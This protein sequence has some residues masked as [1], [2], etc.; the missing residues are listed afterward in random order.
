MI[1]PRFALPVLPPTVA[2]LLSGRR[3]TTHMKHAPVQAVVSAHVFSYVKALHRFWCRSALMGVNLGTIATGDATIAD[4]SWDLFRL[5]LDVA[6]G[7]KHACAKN[8][9]PH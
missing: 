9:K 4:V 7:R 5:M 2:F 6:S 1:R 8:L 3:A